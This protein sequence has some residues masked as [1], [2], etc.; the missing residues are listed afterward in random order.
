M[1][2][3]S[4]TSEADRKRAELQECLDAGQQTYV[5]LCKDFPGIENQI[6]PE[7]T[8]LAEFIKFLQDAGVLTEIQVMDFQIEHTTR[9]I[10]YMKNVR[11]KIEKV[12]KTKLVVPQSSG[13]EGLIL[14]RISTKK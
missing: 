10:E 9:T 12:R 1:T 6:N 5:Q 13:S 4:A 11:Q 8:V 14:P 2:N 7:G 3:K